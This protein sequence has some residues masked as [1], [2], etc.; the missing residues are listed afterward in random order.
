MTTRFRLDRNLEPSFYAIELEPDLAQFSFTGRESITIRAHKPFSRVVLHAAELIITSA[1]LCP[2]GKPSSASIASKRIAYDKE[3]ETATIDFG[4]TCPAGSDHTLVLEFTGTINDKMRGFYRTSYQVNGEKRWGAAT[5]FE[6]T[7]ARRAFPCWD[8]PDRKA[9]FQLTL[10][11]PSHL[12]ALSN[13]PIAEE[14]PASDSGLKQMRYAPSPRM[15]TYLLA[16]VIAELGS[17]EARDKNGVLTRIW[18]TP[19]KK[20]QGRFALDVALHALPYFTR[21]FK[22]PYA[23]PKLDMVAL[24]D[25]ASGAMEN[26][27]LVTYRETALLVD[28]QQSS[29]QA[30]QRVAEVIAHEL[31]HQ[32][33]GNLAT[34]EWWTDLWLNEGFAS[35]MGPKAVDDQFPEWQV[36][37]QYV[38]GEYLMALHEDSLKN[39]HPIEIPVKDPHEIR[40]IF[41]AITYSKGSAVNRMLEH[42]LTE[43]VFRKGLSV[44]LKRYAYRN[45]TTQDL[46][47]VLE[48][49]SG[50]PVKAIMASYTKQEGYPVLL[51]RQKSGASAVE[52]E[53][54]RFLFDGGTDSAKKRWSV[55]IVAIAQGSRRPIYHILRSARTTLKMPAKTGWIKLNAGHSGFYRVAYSPELLER[56]AGAIATQQ[57]SAIDCLGILDDA[58]ALARAGYIR[59]SGALDLV[60]GCRGYVDYNVWLTISGLLQA[61]ENLL[62]GAESLGHLQ[63]LSRELLRP[64]AEQVGWNP[65]PSDGHLDSLLR[66]LVIARLGHGADSATIQEARERF[67]RFTET[68]RLSP[69]IRGAVYATVAEHGAASEYEQFL[70][71]YRKFDLQE[72]RVRVLRALTRFR[73]PAIIRQVLDFSLSDE[74]RRQDAYVV[75]AG[76]GLNPDGRALAWKFIKTNW[77]TL[78]NRYSN[79]G[80]NLMTRIIEGATSHFTAPQ[81]LEDVRGFFKTHPVPG[82]ER[83]MKKSLEVIRS[84]IRWAKRDGE[85]IR[86]WLGHRFS[87]SLQDTNAPVRTTNKTLS[88]SAGSFH[89]NP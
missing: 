24:P 59:T 15:S 83:A 29:A 20:H 6:A 71:I 31:A 32:W 80:L 63:E 57:P 25:F 1:T 18:T 76:F 44:Y 41:D 2:S 37:N 75:L 10:R 78:T 55:P 19:G 82:T 27:G 23:L 74:V 42:Y 28:P 49:V 85:D 51:T 79:G 73:V 13:M 58:I 53:Q 86:C 48:E 40:E 9:V 52:I 17:I 3:M 22:I 14:R 87:T 70:G 65:K 61:V 45:A 46:W 12:T 16:W 7:D 77:K 84:S 72:E 4:A 8:E 69:D 36:W 30:R 39:S 88:T 21:W 68:G 54:R 38:A 81:M 89:K 56:L 47:S 33:F 67:Q 60:A 43:P 34:M 62:D 11:V 66:S 26:W 35:Y 50:K 64:I 5:Q